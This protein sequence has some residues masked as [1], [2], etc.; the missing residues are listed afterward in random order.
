MVWASVDWGNEQNQAIKAVTISMERD[1]LFWDVAWHNLQLPPEDVS[2]VEDHVD[3]PDEHPFWQPRRLA[4]GHQ[5]RSQVAA[6]DATATHAQISA[7]TG[8]AEGLVHCW[9]LDIMDHDNLHKFGSPLVGHTDQVTAL[10]ADWRGRSA[11]SGSCDSTLRLWDVGGRRCDGLLLGHKGSIRTLVADWIERRAIST[12][13][14]DAHIWDLGRHGGRERRPVASLAVHCGV[15]ESLVTFSA[16][17]AAFVNRTG[18]EFW[19]LEP[20]VRT[21]SLQCHPGTLFAIHLGGDE[22][23]ARAE[24]QPSAEP[25]DTEALPYLAGLMPAVAGSCSVGW[26]RTV[27]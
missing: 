26:C 25:E 24:E 2:E 12:S 21:Y 10:S 19:D 11:L 4:S 9:S 13:V 15:C 14:D 1:V 5:Y 22:M 8:S 3:E 20:L 16:G 27:L 7:L 6:Y 18:I 23:D 17:S